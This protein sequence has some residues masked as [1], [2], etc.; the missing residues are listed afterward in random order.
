MPV[1]VTIALSTTSAIHSTP[2]NLADW[3]G[4]A[5]RHIRFGRGVVRTFVTLPTYPDIAD[6][7]DLVIHATITAV[8]SMTVVGVQRGVGTATILSDE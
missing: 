6:E 5:L 2:H 7:P 8:T 3:G 4:P 1:T